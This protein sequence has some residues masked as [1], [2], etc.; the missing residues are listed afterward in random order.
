MALR[1][2]FK[3]SPV[4]R[5]IQRC[6]LRLLVWSYQVYHPVAVAGRCLRQGERSCRDRW[7]LIAPQLERHQIRTLLDLGC[8]E[9]FFVRQA[10]AI[11]GCFAL[12]IDADVR[13]LTIAQT[14]SILDEAHNA[15][16]ML[17]RVTPD[18]VDRLPE[19]DA[20]LFLSVLHHVMSEHGEDHARDLLRR[21]RLKTRALMIFDMGHSGETTQAWAQRLPAM[22]DEP[23][24]WIAGFLRSAGYS[25]TEKLGETDG[26]RGSGRRTVFLALP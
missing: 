6:V 12:G 1:L 19:F 22:G 2:D 18:F 5:A 17:A 14:A 4:S 10:A 8:A 23:D 7:A 26:Y 3:F 16:F 25:Q 9:G 21:I 13:R 24:R 15:G 11:E 20:V